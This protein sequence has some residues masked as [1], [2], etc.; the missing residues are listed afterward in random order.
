LVR[1]TLKVFFIH[2]ELNNLG[3]STVNLNCTIWMRMIIHYRRC[4]CSCFP[5]KPEQIHRVTEDHV[6]IKLRQRH[7]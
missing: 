3:V 1:Q 6:T 5:D 4:L 2:S 7:S